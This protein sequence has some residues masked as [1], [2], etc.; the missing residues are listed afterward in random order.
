MRNSGCLEYLDTLYAHWS[1][2]YDLAVKEF[3]FR[4]QEQTLKVLEK[5]LDFSYTNPDDSTYQQ[6][7]YKLKQGVFRKNIGD[8]TLA[9]K[10]LE[11]L[12]VEIESPVDRPLKIFQIYFYALYILSDIEKLKSNYNKAIEYL[13]QAI[14]LEIQRALQQ[15]LP[16]HIATPLA[17][18]AELWEY[19]ENKEDALR[20][21]RNSSDNFIETLRNQ[22]PDW[23]AKYNYHNISY[24]RKE[25]DFAIQ[26]GLME[27]SEYL[28]DVIRQLQEADHIQNNKT[29]L[30]LAE[31]FLKSE[32]LDSSDYYYQKAKEG[33]FSISANYDEKLRYHLSIASN[34][35]SQ[36]TS[37]ILHAIQQAETYSDSIR[38]TSPIWSR[39]MILVTKIKVAYLKSIGKDNEVLNTVAKLVSELKGR[40]SDA[41]ILKDHINFVQEFYPI[42]ELGLEVV[43]DNKY[44]NDDLTFQILECT[45][46]LSLYKASAFS[47]QN[48]AQNNEE[49]VQ[50]YKYLTALRSQ[51]RLEI[52]EGKETIINQNRLFELNNQI[53][54]LHQNITSLRNDINLDVFEYQS[55]LEAHEHIQCFAGS[56]N[57]YFNLINKHRTKLI[58]LPTSE[59]EKKAKTLINDIDNYNSTK[60]KSSSQQLLILLNPVLQELRRKNILISS[61]GILNLVPLD[62]LQNNDE[63]PLL[64]TFAFSRVPSAKIYHYLKSHTTPKE[65]RPVI[66]RPS[67][68][69]SELPLDYAEQECEAVSDLLESLYFANGDA[70]KDQFIANSSHYNLLHLAT[71]ARGINEDPSLSYIRFTNGKLSFDEIESLILDAELVYLSACETNTGQNYT[72]EGILSLSRN[73]LASGANAVVSS[74][75]SI[76]DQSTSEITVNFYRYLK[77]GESKSE[78]LR[79]AKLDFIDAH[80]IEGKHPYY[81]AGLIIT[82]NDRPLY[83]DHNWLYWIAGIAVLLLILLLLKK[84]FNPSH[85]V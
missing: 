56:R 3:D 19:L 38:N 37:V 50:R 4:E 43:K 14:R 70:T 25:L 59:V 18:K 79:K 84:V 39:D 24:L 33:I 67:E 11:E 62:A 73:F 48:L 31:Y 21:Y 40:L 76:P 30:L 64:E 75:W 81:W 29:Y 69:P 8:L 83:M 1:R 52:A 78:S 49:E 57:Y 17:R 23:V 77:K 36:D 53:E 2:R 22:T 20:L 12:L 15:K 27:R 80:P 61:D 54:K 51:Y 34:R 82:G 55:I 9:K 35:F 74:L 60:Y 58:S 63:I 26:H 10:T 47:R 71:H 16:P 72:G 44:Q 7:D 66:F 41:I 45:K 42:L 5:L 85:P 32:Q 46:A 28:I 13:D 65:I 68:D 6:L